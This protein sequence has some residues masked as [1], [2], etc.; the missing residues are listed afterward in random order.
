MHVKWFIVVFYYFFVCVFTYYILDSFR[1]ILYYYIL[2]FIYLY[3]NYIGMCII[4]LLLFHL[5]FKLKKK[6]YYYMY[7]YNIININNEIF[8]ICIAARSLP[9]ISF[10]RK[11]WVLEVPNCWQFLFYINN[12]IFMST[13]NHI[14]LCL[15]IY[16]LSSLVFRDC[17]CSL[18]TGQVINEHFH[19]LFHYIVIVITVICNML[20]FF[21][22]VVYTSCFVLHL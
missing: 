21:Y 7:E 4:L 2:I 15:Y 11:N 18:C 1:I 12:V 13:E 6:S 17:C 10:F 20:M 9:P 16:I 8:I 14:I 22:I 3:D 5:L 19:P